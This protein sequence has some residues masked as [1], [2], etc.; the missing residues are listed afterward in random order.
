MVAGFLNRSAQSVFFFPLLRFRS[1]LVFSLSKENKASLLG[2]QDR[3]TAP[4]TTSEL[5]LA[6]VTLGDVMTL[7]TC[8]HLYRLW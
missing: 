8:C 6:E 1:L 3:T 7:L 2:G 5:W 4:R